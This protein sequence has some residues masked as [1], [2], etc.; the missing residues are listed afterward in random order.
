M[1]R[2][3]NVRRNAPGPTDG[4]LA[5]VSN[6]K[7]AAFG[8]S[9]FHYGRFIPGGDYRAEHPMAQTRSLRVCCPT[10]QLSPIQN[11]HNH[12]LTLLAI[13]GSL[14]LGAAISLAQNTGNSSLLFNHTAKGQA[15]WENDRPSGEHPLLAL[16]AS[17][18]SPEPT[19][20]HKKLSRWLR[21]YQDAKPGSAEEAQSIAAIRTMGTNAAPPLVQML[22]SGDMKSQQSAVNAFKILGPLGVSA[23]PG[24]T[25][26][27][28]HTNVMVRIMAANSLGHIGAPA[29][30][31]M[32]NALTNSEYNIATLAT[33]AIVELGNDAAPAIPVF[34]DDLGSRDPLVRERA[35]DALGSLHLQPEIVVPALE[36]LLGDHSRM[37]RCL[38]LS[39]LG[40]FQAAAKMATPAIVPLLHDPDEYVR[41][42]ATNSLCNIAPNSFSRQVPRRL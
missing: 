5:N 1:S 12:I 42:F 3:R 17:G 39:S 7:Q 14:I 41:R 9:L 33:F 10:K 4:N 8:W 19:F 11:R 15:A 31:A 38:A 30:P 37:A 13:S 24:L 35:A 27:L 29:L 18:Q 22:T 6:L 23:I 16:G 26:L 21:L 28:N 36:Q 2:I 32:M 20:R 40:Q 25:T 34:L